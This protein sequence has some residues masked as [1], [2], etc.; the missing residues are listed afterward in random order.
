M[1]IEQEK[2]LF[3]F[4]HGITIEQYNDC[5]VSVIRYYSNRPNML[6]FCNS[7]QEL[8]LWIEGV[9]EKVATNKASSILKAHNMLYQ[10]V[11]EKLIPEKDT[12]LS[13]DVTNLLIRA[14]LLGR[15]GK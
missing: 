2:E 7:Q 10:E 8:N 3:C 1:L 5:E 15:S 13:G 14:Y 9:V 11:L 6:K 4:V 12:Y